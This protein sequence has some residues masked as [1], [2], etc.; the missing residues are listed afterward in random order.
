MKLIWVISIVAIN[1]LLG[2]CNSN[3]VLNNPTSISGRFSN[4]FGGAAKLIANDGEGFSPDK[5]VGQGQLQADGT[6]NLQLD[7]I[8]AD[9]IL[10]IPTSNPCE[11][12]QMSES[13]VRFYLNVGILVEQDNE[14]TGFIIQTSM[15]SLAPGGD[16]AIGE[17][18]VTYWYAN[19]DVTVTGICQSGGPED[20][21]MYNLTLKKGWN[22][23]VIER[24]NETERSF[25]TTS[26]RGLTWIFVPFSQ[27]ITDSPQILLL[28]NLYQ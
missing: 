24:L 10:G 25:T 7:A 8:A 17:R 16:L 27:T 14:F 20:K 12:V 28:Q 2:A 19:K 5:T 6:F 3:A 9:D 1:F 15:K 18:A 4:Y 13:E 23:V 21:T 26:T 22:S 11:G